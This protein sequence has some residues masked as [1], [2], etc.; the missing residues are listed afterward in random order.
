MPLSA[1][2]QHDQFL[3]ELQ[4][5]VLEVITRWSSRGLVLHGMEFLLSTPQESSI[6]IIEVKFRCCSTMEDIKPTIFDMVSALHNS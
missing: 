6:P 2:K 3:Q 1:N 5:S 4:L